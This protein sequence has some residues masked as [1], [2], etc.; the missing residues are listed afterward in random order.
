MSQPKIIFSSSTLIDGNTSRQKIINLLL[1]NRHI[2]IAQFDR[3]LKPKHPKFLTPR[4]FGVSTPQL[5][6]A[7]TRIKQ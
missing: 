4:R 5:K 3:F 6:K 7:V 1:K 2:S